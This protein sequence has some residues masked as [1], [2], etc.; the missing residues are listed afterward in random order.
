M[1]LLLNIRR[2]Q[3]MV[4]ALVLGAGLT[5][6]ANAPQVE[7]ERD[8][9]AFTVTASALIDAD[10]RTAWDTI[11]D[12]ERLPD[13][14]PGLLR[15]TVVAREGERLT[16][17]YVGEF[18]IYFFRVPVRMRLAA[19]HTPFTQV[20]A[21]STPPAAGVPPATLKDFRARYDLAV[22][23]VQQRAGVRLDY[24]ARFELAQPLPP[25]LGALFGTAAVRRTMRAQFEALVAQ[26]EQR[27]R[28]RPAIGKG[29]P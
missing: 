23:R 16:I 11:V 26:I 29:A 7:V 9:D 27:T 18:Q 22:V 1:Q 28:A 19:Q 4:A 6:R 8:G 25:V 15:V 21:Q 5:A 24:R 20:Q 12:Y 13:F 10:P 2:A 17:D 3:V 14:V